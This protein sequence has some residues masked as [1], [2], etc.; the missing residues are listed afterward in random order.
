M[1]ALAEKTGMLVLEVV[2]IGWLA[3]AYGFL[4]AASRAPLIE[5][6][7]PDSVPEVDTAYDFSSQ[8]NR[9]PQQAAVKA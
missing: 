6:P 8:I 7:V 1:S 9:Q 4:H 5:G 3:C 2:G